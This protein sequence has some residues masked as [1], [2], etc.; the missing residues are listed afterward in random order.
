[1]KERVL[2]TGASG[3]V[4][5][6]LVVEALSQGYEV[7][8]A[9]RERS[10]IDQLRGLALR[11]VH[12]DYNSNDQLQKELENNHFDYIIHAAGITKAKNQITYIQVNAEASKSLAIASLKANGSLKKFVLVS[13]LAA[14]GPL[15][16][17][18]TL[19]YD[20]SEP[21]PVTAYGRSK[22]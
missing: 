4:G 11:Y 7:Y 13:S 21:R 15:T 2:I 12:L 16:K 10:K 17:L 20:N 14:L 18:D 1:M 8:A 3:F 9:I 6:H 22:L 19:I 5:Y